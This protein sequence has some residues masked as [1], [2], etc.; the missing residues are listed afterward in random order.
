VL[1][2][3]PLQARLWRAETRLEQAEKRLS[4]ADARTDSLIKTVNLN[5]AAANATTDRLAAVAKIVDLNA[6]ELRE[7]G[8]LARNANAHAHSHF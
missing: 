1:V 6:D 2:V 8:R 3:R 5:A 4:A 7:V